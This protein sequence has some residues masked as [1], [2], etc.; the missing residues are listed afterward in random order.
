M[1]TAP[2]PERLSPSEKTP[3]ERLRRR[4]PD[5]VIVGV[6]AGLAVV[7]VLAIFLFRGADDGSS[8]PSTEP[9]AAGT[10]ADLSAVE[11]AGAEVDDLFAQAAVAE[12]LPGVEV[13]DLPVT[14]KAFQSAGSLDENRVER[15]TFGPEESIQLVFEQPE[16]AEKT[17]WSYE[18]TEVG[19]GA[20]LTNVN[21]ILEPGDS[22]RFINV[23]AATPVGRYVAAL[24]SREGEVVAATAFEITD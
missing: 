4:R 9:A 18:L 15:T 6:V 12:V 14:V 16:I 5:L 22:T 1:S 7:A 3:P 23:P 21:V 11:R 19:T 20:V 8:L 24:S 2:A 10:D 13:A 17:V